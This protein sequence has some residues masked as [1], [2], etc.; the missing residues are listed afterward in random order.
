MQVDILKRASFGNMA[1]IIAKLSFKEGEPYP[2][3]G[4]DLAS[5]LNL[6]RVLDVSVTGMLDEEYDLV[7]N[8]ET[9]RLQIL[10]DNNETERTGGV[11]GCT[12]T[13]V[14]Q[15]YIYTP[16]SIITPPAHPGYAATG[17]VTLSG[18]VNAAFITEQGSGYTSVPGVRIAD[19][20]DVSG[21]RTATAEAQ[22]INVGLD[23]VELTGGVNTAGSGYTSPPN[24]TVSAPQS[25]TTA[26]ANAELDVTNESI[27][28][29]VLLDGGSG[30]TR[31]PDIAIKKGSA[32][33]NTGAALSAT[34]GF[35]VETI[36]VENKGY[37][38]TSA[39]TVTITN[40]SGDTHG[41]GATATATTTGSGQV[42]RVDITNGGSVYA[43]S[44]GAPSV[45]FSGGGGSGAVAHAELAANETVARVVV[46][47]GGSGYTSAPT[48]TFSA[49]PN[50]FD[51]GASGVARLGPEIDAITLTN[52]GEG[53]TADPTVT[54]TG[55]NGSG[56]TATAERN[57]AGKIVALDVANGGSG[58][59][60]APVTIS[61]GGG[62]GATAYATVGKGVITGIT[63]SN[64]GSG[65][66]H[67]QYTINI[68]P[69]PVSWGVQAT[70]SSLYTP[71][72]VIGNNIRI[73]N[74]GTGYSNASPPAITVTSSTG[75][76][77]TFNVAIDDTT[78][79]RIAG[80]EVHSGG[81]GYGTGVAATVGGYGTG[82][83]TSVSHSNGVID[84]IR[85]VNG[86]SGYLPT[87]EFSGG[88]GS[89]ASA[90]A[91][92]G[93]GVISD[94]TMT[95]GGYGYTAAPPV[96]V[97]STGGINASLEA[98]LRDGAVSS[99][100]I[101]SGGSGYTSVP[102]ISIAAPS[103]GTR[104]TATASVASS[105][106]TGV[107]VTNRGQDYESVPTVTT[108]ETPVSG[109]DNFT[110]TLDYDGTIK[111]VDITDRGIYHTG[112]TPTITF[113]A[114]AS[115][116]GTRAT[117][118]LTMENIPGITGSISAITVTNGGS[119]WIGTPTV[120]VTSTGGGSGFQG[121]VHKN[122]Q[123][124]ITGVT[125]DNA[126]SGYSG[127]ITVTFAGNGTGADATATLNAQL[128]QVASVT[129]ANRG[130]GY[131]STPTVTFTT[132]TQTGEIEGQTPKAATGYGVLNAEIYS[133]THSGD[134]Q[135]YT[136]PTLQFSGGG[137]GSGATAT[138]TIGTGAGVVDGITITQG[139]NGY[140]TAPALTFS[141]GGG[142]G[143]AATT[144]L[145]N[146]V[147]GVSIYN[148]GSGYANGDALTFATGVIT[149]FS[150]FGGTVTGYAD[151]EAVTLSGAGSNRFWFYGNCHC[152][153]NPCNVDWGNNHNRRNKLH[154]GN[155][156]NYRRGR[157]K[158]SN[159]DTCGIGRSGRGR[160]SYS[161]KWCY[162]KCDCNQRWK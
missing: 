56:A 123:N 38:Y 116:S 106:I 25:G 52:V 34:L 57:P 140:T 103:G 91:A 107:T 94:T 99:T 93:D 75:S 157:R 88:G 20:P 155:C 76:G 124:E 11:S 138:A 78:E 79:G 53:Y 31:A 68:A 73:D 42:V 150:N 100:S 62:S 77:A 18:D 92:Y 39:P 51:T 40:A 72:G 6:D 14:G 67:N 153:G 35:P 98:I 12:I 15:N 120:G 32:T 134:G 109:S 146:Y 130:T 135:W 61:G 30:Y 121:T 132:P 83:T 137:G 3:G 43:Y 33:D 122:A 48:V 160:N 156:N 7:W 141:G 148:G 113:P 89:G 86:G 133:I 139:G 47:N 26:T 28:N 119:G 21:K 16:N 8:S 74:G 125:I 65:Y 22:M 45:T 44:A 118:T 23:D 129:M 37:G 161:N 126:G 131:S 110:V 55:G 49:P 41:S 97:T 9:R 63:V 102:T 147:G 111:R 13:S 59:S 27:S 90:T 95:N 142:T 5:I 60:I 108:V 143:A 101:T 69:P 66:V 144:A 152:D 136:A 50:V 87:I 58:F 112:D 96:G 149:G 145:G 105:A 115:G 81:S 162:N 80:I 71:G 151:N 64:G 54:I 85:V 159:R 29:V 19:P 70:A 2:K 17:H 84:N 104:A 158:Y 1:G 46:T 154:I 10:H 82:A 4:Y 114:P 127:D 24:V 36:T 117:A 128:K